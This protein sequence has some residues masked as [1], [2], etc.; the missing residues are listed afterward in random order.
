MSEPFIGEIQ[1]YGLNFNPR[2]WA[3][4]RGDSLSISQNSALFSLLGIAYGGNGTTTFL[5]PNLA[6]RV[7]VGQGQSPGAGNYVIGQTFG[8]ASVTLTSGEIPAHV[9][10]NPSIATGPGADRSAGPSNG[11][12][13]AAPVQTRAF[14]PAS[15]TTLSP[16]ALTSVGGGG[17]H[18]NQQ[19]YL[20]LNYCIALEGIY[21]SRN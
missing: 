3:F 12:R 20:A 13:L 5:L 14:R 1:L 19:P 9:H 10:L 4:C 8:A 2:G 18:E 6:G 11:A 17:A 15:N 16:A 7:P 21:P